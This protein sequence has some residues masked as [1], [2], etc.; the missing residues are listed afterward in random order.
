[1]HVFFTNFAA[2]IVLPVLTLFRNNTISTAITLFFYTVILHVPAL[3][4]LIAMPVENKP[5]ALLFQSLAPILAPNALIS[6]CS[7][8]VL[9]YIQALLINSLVDEYRLMGDRNWLPAALYVLTASF[10]P[11]FQWIS[12]PLIATTFVIIAIRQ[13]YRLYKEPTATGMVFDTAFWTT[14]GS[15]FY[16]PAL[17]MIAAAFISIFALRSFSIREQIV[18]FSGIF[19]PVFLS[20][21]TCFTLDQGGAFRAELADFPI[22]LYHIEAIPDVYTLLKWGAIA[23]LSAFVILNYTG[24]VSR[25]SMPS[26]KRISATYWFLILGLASAWLQADP[27]NA[28]FL[29]IMP[30]LGMFWGLTFHSIRNRLFAEI[31]HLALVALLVLL[32]F[33]PHLRL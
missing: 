20:W 12:A 11:D 7:A 31:G 2:A 8:I 23:A 32:H 3:A 33:Y 19:V 16:A 21:L 5:N 24:L 9:V 15:L 14:L 17:W 22:G 28:H 10:L 30:A 4:G 18:F 27:N 1:L 29:L 6:A 26:A 25:K 13:V